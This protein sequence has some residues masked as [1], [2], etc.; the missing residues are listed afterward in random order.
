MIKIR[1]LLIVLCL[2]TL[3]SSLFAGGFALSG[4]GSRATAMGGAFRG[5]ADDSSAMFWNPAGLAFMDENSVSLGG[6]FIMPSAKWDPTGTTVVGIPGYDAKE[7]EAEKSLRTFP[8]VFVTIAK[9]PQLKYGLGVY[10]PYGLGTTW[11]AYQLPSDTYTY[12]AGFPEKEMS[13]SIAVIDVHPSVAYQIMPN[14]S[15]GAGLSVMYGTI[16]IAKIG[17][18]QALTS[19]FL[20]PDAMVYVSPISTELSGAGLGF[21]ANLGVM[22]KPMKDLSLGLSG[23]LPSQI[24]MSGDAEVYFWKPAVMDSLGAVVSAEARPGGPADIE[25]TLKLPAEIGFGIAYNVK[26][27]WKV[28]LDYAYTMWDR[29]D[30]V[31]VEMKTPIPT[32]G[33]TSSELSFNWENTSRISLGTEYNL[34]CNTVRAGFYMDQSPI[35]E[36]TQTPT[37]SDIGNKISANLG[38]GRF[39]GN[40]GV[41]ANFQYVM[42]SEREVTTQAV[43][44][45]M[46][47]TNMLGKYNANSLS[48]NIGLTYK[49]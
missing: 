42:F 2:A 23:K 1:H 19:V 49:F 48:G 26:P 12:V 34:G 47:P 18:S 8:N 38:W 14:L 33:I 20:V 29:L 3:A 22:F 16:D 32:L 6:T 43:D 21:G 9:H 40:I 15:A 25:S 28:S 27:N 5:L 46:S 7:Y 36:S 10:V 4:V 45:S 30:K 39:F 41:D 24:K 31:L 11:D 35:P 13:S 17:F 44:A 37:L